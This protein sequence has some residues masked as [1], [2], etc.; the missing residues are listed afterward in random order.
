MKSTIF[1]KLVSFL[2][3]LEQQNI[4][5]TLAHHRD[6]AIMV[7]VA[8]PGERWEIEFL[9]DGSVEVEKFV[10]NGEIAGEEALNELFARYLQQEELGVESS[11][12]TEMVIVTG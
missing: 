10:S 5:Y 11:Q 9:S 2:Q 4:V 1:D 8:V 3:N 12:G 7:T 6:E